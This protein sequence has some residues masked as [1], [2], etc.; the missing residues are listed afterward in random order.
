MRNVLI[1]AQ[2]FPPLGGG[3]VIRMVKFAKYLPVFGWNP[4][5]LTLSE[6]QH[7]GNPIDPSLMAQLDPKLTII[8]AR[9]IGVRGQ[10]A[11]A[12]SSGGAA[13]DAAQMPT[14][15]MLQTHSST[16]RRTLKSITRRFRVWEDHGYLWLPNATRAAL[17]AATDYRIDAV[18]TTSPPHA[19]Q[20]IGYWLKRLRHLPWVVDFRD[21]WTDDPLFQSESE[22]RNRLERAQERTI[23][24]NADHV[25]CAAETIRGD[26]L[27]KYAH[28]SPEGVEVLLNGY[29]PEDFAPP[30][31]G[32]GETTVSSAL[33]T[34]ATQ[35]PLRISYLGSV[36]GAGRP[37]E[38]FLQ[39]LRNLAAEGAGDVEVYFV[40]TMPESDRAKATALP[41]VHVLGFLPH[42]EAVRHMQSADVLL[43]IMGPEMGKAV[44]GKLYEYA[45]AGKP[46]LLLSGPGPSPNLVR[47]NQW[48]WVCDT[49][50]TAGITAALREC[51]RLYQAGE[52]NGF[53]PSPTSMEKYDRRKGTERL[54][55]ILDSLVA[56]SAT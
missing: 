51:L 15:A 32:M 20:W 34:E 45:A 9:T 17:K 29:D 46:I 42:D 2:N 22:L 21:G 33:Q 39:A 47:Q 27:R 31:P 25:I 24:S 4:I 54:A 16:V 41:N 48:G 44:A 6:D 10:A 14:E 5:V 50:D 38:P 8:R 55:R 36:G 26:L 7:V 12:A 19:T 28:L 13:P 3:G 23:V 52:L 43:G 11:S 56:H 18:L 40:G 53:A 37:I 30:P 49:F 1:C 35:P